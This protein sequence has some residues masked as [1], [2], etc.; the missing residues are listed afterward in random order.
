[1]V[2]VVNVK[3]T[4]EV[5]VV[6]N[7]RQYVTVDGNPDNPA[8]VQ[9]PVSSIMDYLNTEGASEIHMERDT[10]RTFTHLVR[11]GLVEYYP[12]ILRPADFD[13]LIVAVNDMPV[14]P[15][16]APEVTP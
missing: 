5:E 12:E 11:G 13:A 9:V 2:E 4:G 16:P 1:M 10:F 3:Q 15:E 7:L 8:S 14:N 6:T